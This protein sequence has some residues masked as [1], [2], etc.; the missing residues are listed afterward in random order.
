[1]IERLRDI[2]IINELETR[3]NKI[4]DS[5]H[6][7]KHFMNSIDTMLT[8]AKRLYE[9]AVRSEPEF[10]EHGVIHTK[11]ILALYSE[12]LQNCFC[13]NAKTPEDRDEKEKLISG[14]E[15]FLLIAAAIWHDVAMADGRMD[16]ANR[17]NDARY[18]Q[19]IVSSLSAF[20]DEVKHLYCEQILSI[21]CSHSHDESL[22]T[23]KSIGRRE[24]VGIDTVIIRTKMLAGLLRLCD[25]LSDDSSRS[26][27]LALAS[28]ADESKVFW[29]HSKYIILSEIAMDNSN[30]QYQNVV[31][32]HYRV[33]Y[34]DMFECYTL[35]DE[36]TVSLYQFIINR[37]SKVHAEMTMCCPLFSEV[38]VLGKLEVHIEIVQDNKSI[39]QGTINL[40]NGIT[41]PHRPK[42]WDDIENSIVVKTHGNYSLPQFEEELRQK[43]QTRS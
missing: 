27:N 14:D 21:A 41:S 43:V 40:D 18:V 37:I 12:I 4:Q 6:R 3:I 9:Q 22:L 35:Q 7:Y 26:N 25:E 10:N 30:R 8:I 36:Q 1:M 38:A 31:K 29:L 23:C 16:H 28:V 19:E 13:I 24:R 17:L 11:L 33:P 39:W 34:E 2:M 5:E 42:Y 20:S 15:V 32:I